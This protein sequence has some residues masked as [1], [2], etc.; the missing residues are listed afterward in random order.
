MK[1]PKSSS[2]HLKRGLLALGLV[3]GVGL[4]QWSP[5]FFLSAQ[6]AAQAPTGLR[7]ILAAQIPVGLIEDDFVSSLGESWGDWSKG[8]AKLVADLYEKEGLDT[9]GQREILGSLKV[10]LG[11]MEKALADAK[12][13]AILDKLAQQHGRLSRRVWV[14]QGALDTLELN[15][16][17]AQ[18]NRVKSA[19]LKAAEAAKALDAY[20]GGIEN[21]QSWRAFAKTSDVSKLASSEVPA[22]VISTV[23]GRLTNL[24]KLQSDDQRKF[25]Q[26]TVFANLRSAL[27]EYVAV[28]NAPAPT[29]NQAALRESLKK[30]VE[31][32]EKYE[33]GRSIED[34]KAARATFAEIRKQ[35]ADGGEVLGDAL[36][37]S[38]FNYNTRVI[39]SETFLTKVIGEQQKETGPVDD[40]VLGAKV[41]GTQW[42][43]TSVGVDLV[44][45]A[46]D[47]RFALTLTGISQTSTQGVTDQ[48]TI[49][50]SGYHQFWARKTIAFDGD[51]FTTAPGT[52][53]VQANNTTTGAR[54]RVSGVPLL[55]SIADNY[56]VGEAGNRRGASEAIAAD[57]LRNRV[58]PRFD[59]EADSKFGEYSKQIESDVNEKLRAN[60]LFP[61]ARSYRTT[62]TDLAI[63]TR[64]MENGELGGDSTRL[65]AGSAIGA[66]VHLHETAIN[67]ALDRLGLGGK[68]LTEDELAVELANAVKTLTGKVINL[69]KKDNEK[70]DNTKFV[71]PA[72]DA[73]RIRLQDGQVTLIFRMGLKPEDSEAIPTQEIAVPIAISIAGNDVKLEAGQ[74]TVSPVEMVTN[75]V[76]QRARAAVVTTKIQKALPTRTADR[77]IDIKRGEGAAVKVAVTQVKANGG[78][79]SIVLE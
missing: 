33:E 37:A 11:T 38:Y 67:N 23:Q 2:R 42:T 73:L 65:T 47:I 70:P 26:R 18:A 55:G 21:G 24:D 74:V 61:S 54:T 9:A 30:L 10:K 69:K 50:T 68:S 22:E 53:N 28:V 60:G 71:F 59:Q 1:F 48:A 66:S 7:G 76:E 29:V 72:Q 41:D 51:R 25:V 75:P 63:S 8:T 64:L 5:S 77:F 40:Y 32:L 43:T 79:L 35:A 44:P 4:A 13:G 58:L 27:D 46:K 17:T 39:A 19:Q 6:E 12:Y 62:D 57:K 49:F 36:S 16:Q 34:A 3:A 78:W 15:P 31:S 56:A 45:S 20:L 52:I 14:A